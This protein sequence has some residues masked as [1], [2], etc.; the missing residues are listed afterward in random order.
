MK[1][2]R[3]PFVLV[4]VAVLGVG[5]YAWFSRDRKSRSSDHVADGETANDGVLAVYKQLE[6]ATQTGNGNLFVSLMSQKKTEEAKNTQVLDQLRQGSPADPSV[7]YEVRGIKTRDDHAAILGKVISSN[8]PLQYHLVR[9]ILENGS[10]KIAEERLD[11]DPIDPS[12]L[13]AAVPAQDGAFGRS[14]SPWDRVP[15]A[16]ENTKRFKEDQIDWKFKATNDESFVYIRFESRVPLAA[17]GT[18]LTA[19]EAKSSRSTPDVMVIK[20]ATGKQFFL[21]VGASPT[22]RGTFDE[23][24]H[25]ISN[26]YFV[27][28][29]FSLKDAARETL[30][31]DSTNDMYEPLIATQNRFL[32]I[33]I[34]LKCLGPDTSSTDIEMSEANS[35][36]KILPYALLRFSE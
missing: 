33:R 1:N 12:V 10:W 8:G 29:S 19:D 21:V 22:T 5:T 13:E 23:G 6:K 36:A 26:R 20:T 28:Y 30:F 35:V 14:G 18:E 9:F 11:S 15:Y 34:P 24:G 17:A 31:S 25:A 2:V 3:V 4:I 27:Q 7:R 32:D 16:N